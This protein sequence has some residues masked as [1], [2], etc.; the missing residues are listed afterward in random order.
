ML[1]FECAA[2][3]VASCSVAKVLRHNLNTCDCN[4]ILNQFLGG[5]EHTDPLTSAECDDS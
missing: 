3:L 5:Y 4:K 1:S 2:C